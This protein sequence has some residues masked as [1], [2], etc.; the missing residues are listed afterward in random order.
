MNYKQKKI[1]PVIILPKQILRHS[2]S[3]TF[4][5]ALEQGSQ[6]TQS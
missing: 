3:V 5:R 6:A 4:T 2:D 1:L